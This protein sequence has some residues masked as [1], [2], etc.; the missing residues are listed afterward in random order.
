MK[1]IEKFLAALK[2]NLSKFYLDVFP[3]ESFFD[4]STEMPVCGIYFTQCV[5]VFQTAICLL[6]FKRIR[7]SLQQKNHSKMLNHYLINVRNFCLQKLSDSR[8][9]LQDHI[10]M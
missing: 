4:L 10:E 7:S 3:R 1:Q 8:H 9:L 5:T 6:D 2:V